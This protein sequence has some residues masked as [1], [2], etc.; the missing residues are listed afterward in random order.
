VSSRNEIYF[1]KLIISRITISV[2]AKGKFYIVF[3]CLFAG[4]II[5]GTWKVFFCF[6]PSISNFTVVFEI[7]LLPIAIDRKLGTSELG[8]V[9][10]SSGPNSI[11]SPSS[12]IRS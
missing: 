11:P 2:S 1:Y 8:I 10:P 5:I 7:Y 6:S 3:S 12:K 4:S 9:A